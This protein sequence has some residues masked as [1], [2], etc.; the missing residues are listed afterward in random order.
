MLPD[1]RYTEWT[2]LP[3]QDLYRR[4]REIRL[5]FAA[6]Y[7]DKHDFSSA[8]ALLNPLLAYDRADEPVHCELM[9]LYALAGQR[10][11]ALRQYQTCVEALSAELDVSPEPET[12]TLHAQILSGG[13][14]ASPDLHNLGV[15]ANRSFMKSCRPSGLLVVGRFTVLVKLRT[16]FTAYKS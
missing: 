12:T 10:Y 9:R 6:H 1:H 7:R 2:L 4:Q 14:A 11:E 3:R 8:I 5:A 13:F 16:P 15:E